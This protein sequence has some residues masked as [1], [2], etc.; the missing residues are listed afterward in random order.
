MTDLF[1]KE[2]EPVGRLCLLPEMGCDRVPG[3]GVS[4]HLTVVL[5]PPLCAPM[6]S[7]M[8]SQTAVVEASLRQ[9]TDTRPSGQTMP[10]ATSIPFRTCDVPVVRTS[11]NRCVSV[12]SHV[13]PCSRAGTTAVRRLLSG[14][15]RPRPCDAHPMD[16]L[17]RDRGERRRRDGQGTG[18]GLTASGVGQPVGL[19][20]AEL[21]VQA[22]GDLGWHL[23]RWWRRHAHRA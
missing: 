19:G 8:V 10:S 13:S 20:L 4:T 7:S 23:R 21:L 18:G 12:A 1:G 17:P 16:D 15:S 3:T 6:A 22:R 14:T 11:T 2:V 9:C 5:P